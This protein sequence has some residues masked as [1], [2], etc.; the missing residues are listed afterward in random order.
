MIR[1]V[2]R[3][4]LDVNA[5]ELD[6]SRLSF[7][8]Q[9][10]AERDRRFAE[11][12]RQQP[13]SWQRPPEDVI[14]P[15]GPGGG[16]GYWA[17]VCHRDVREVSRNP[18]TYRSGEGVMFGNMPPQFQSFLAMDAPQ[19][20]AVRGLFQKAFSPRQITSLEAKIRANARRVVEEAAPVGGGD[21]VNLIAKRLPLM[22]VS[23]MLGVPEDE[24]ERVATAADALVS[25]GDAQSVGDRDPVQ[26][27]GRNLVIL[28]RT[29][30]RLAGEREERPT[31]DLLSSIVTAEVDGRKLSHAEIGAFFMLLSIAGNET[32]R[33]T[34]A[35]GM[36][37]LQEFP[38]QREW[39][40]EDLEARLPTA[41]EELIRWAS[42]VMTFRRTATR[43]VELHG[44]SIRAGNW[45]VLFYV[46]ANR[47]EK[48]FESPDE[49]RLDRDPNP[50]V[51]FGGGGPHYCLGAT[52]ARTQMRSIFHELLTRL[53][54]IEV[55]EPEHVVTAFVNGIKRLPCRWTPPG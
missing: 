46:S 1:R 55:G 48:A 35:H 49:L 47:D 53:P 40:M 8:Q 2:E 32:T 6:L 18:E 41:V 45:V 15:M 16:S 30:V 36:R 34:I 10:P 9:S 4:A 27:L 13:I 44:T 26:I 22:T 20:T 19:H 25:A 17:V 33:N 54:D 23:D 5:D 3:V 12:R 50:H 37:A 29:A 52:L 11:L 28:N 39:L 21:F 42:P 51:G 24:R 43:D 38:E 31:G 7:W 14:G